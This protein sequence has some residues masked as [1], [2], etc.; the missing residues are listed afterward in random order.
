M[1]DRESEDKRREGAAQQAPPQE[2]APPAP[3]AT[4]G[5]GGGAPG[6]A[7]PRNPGGILPGGGPGAGPGSIGAEDASSTDGAPAGSVERGG[8]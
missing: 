6:V 7:S 5:I 1:A 4:A 2:E 8:R 3:P